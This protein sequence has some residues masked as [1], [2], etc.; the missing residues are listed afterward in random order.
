MIRCERRCFH[1]EPVC[2]VQTPEHGNKVLC[3]VTPVYFSII[4][5]ISSPPLY[6]PSIT[7]ISCWGA[8]WVQFLSSQISCTPSLY[9]NKPNLIFTLRYQYHL[10]QESILGPSPS[11]LLN[12]PLS[13]ILEQAIDTGATA[14]TSDREGLNLSPPPNPSIVD[15]RLRV[16]LITD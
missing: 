3:H 10:L 16:Y 13:L 5:N 12:C 1:V 4:P 15:I 14:L 6:V 8:V 11:N 7:Q 2:L 9:L